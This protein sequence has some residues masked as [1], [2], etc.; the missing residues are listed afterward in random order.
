MAEPGRTASQPR[1]DEQGSPLLSAI[2]TRRTFNMSLAS[3]ALAGTS[4]VTAKT[5]SKFRRI[6]LLEVSELSWRDDLT[7]AL[8]DRGW[9]QG[10][11]LH[12][13]Q[14]NARGRIEALASLAKDLIRA[15]VE[16]IITIGPNPTRAAQRATTTT[17]LVFVADDAVLGGLVTNLARPGG[18]ATGFSVSTTNLIAKSLAVLKE[19]KPDIRRV[20]MFEVASNPQFRLLRGGFEESCRSIGVAPAYVAVGPAVG[21]DAA[22]TEASRA[23]AD[24]VVLL[25]DSFI[26][27]HRAEILGAA[28]RARIAAIGFEASYARDGA[29]ATYAPSPKND[30]GKAIAQYVDR[31]L[32]GAQCAELPVQQPSLFELTINLKTAERLGI[33]VPRSLLLQAT[34]LIQ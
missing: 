30:L 24:A 3:L 23:H 31:I 18:N 33:K 32:R 6:G 20:C 29:L 27:P 1:P 9:S 8:R 11:N 13:E 28:L 7:E 17:P 5:A 2:A 15:D 14:R 10:V 34:E 21:I 22:I 19:A 12:I 25:S 26:G 4:T 16:L